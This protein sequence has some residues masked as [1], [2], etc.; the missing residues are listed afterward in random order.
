[1]Y[2]KTSERGMFLLSEACYFSLRTVIA[3]KKRE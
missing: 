1:V 2:V 3:K